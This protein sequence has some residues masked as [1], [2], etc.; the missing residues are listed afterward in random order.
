MRRAAVEGRGPHLPLLAEVSG[1]EKLANPC[2]SSSA[3]NAELDARAAVPKLQAPFLILGSREDGY[4]PPSD[5]SELL[6]RAGSAHKRLVLF[7]GDF[8]GW[9]LFS[10]SPDRARATA[11]VI[12][13]LRRYG[14]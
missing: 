13:F 1:E 2:G 11:A 12:H 5:A 4:L 8:H 9:D 14:S 10:R 6:Q 3:L 7:P